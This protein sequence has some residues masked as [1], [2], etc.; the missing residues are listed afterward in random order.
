MPVSQIVII[1]F[2]RVSGEKSPRPFLR[3]KIPSERD[4]FYDSRED[5]KVP[6]DQPRQ[7][8]HRGRRP[9][10]TGFERKRRSDRAGQRE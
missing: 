10:T 8:Q 5:G 6:V 9:K 4:C 7:P 1:D 3:P 2:E